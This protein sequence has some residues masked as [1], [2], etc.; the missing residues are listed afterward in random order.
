[1]VLVAGWFLVR[2]LRWRL[3]TYTLTTHRIVL[4]RGIISRVTESIALDRIQDIVV[5]RPLAERLIRSG[6]VEID[7]AGRDGIEVLRMI[8]HPNRFYTEVLQAVE[9]Y[10]RLSMGLPPSTGVAPAAAFPP[11]PPPVRGGGL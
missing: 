10:R 8:P 9:E 2:L 1:V 7:S 4:S 3:Q 11:P 6:V 5:R